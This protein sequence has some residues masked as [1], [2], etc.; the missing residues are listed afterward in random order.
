MSNKIYKKESAKSFLPPAVAGAMKRAPAAGREVRN[1]AGLVYIVGQQLGKGNFGSVSLC[2]DQFGQ[3]FVIKTLLSD[4]PKEEVF[5]EWKKEKD[6]LTSL[7]HPNIVHAYDGFAY[8]KGFYI[9][10]ERCSG[11]LRDLMK[12]EK[13]FAAAKVVELAGQMLSGLDHIHSHGIIHR[14]LHIDN[15]LYTTINNSLVLKIADFGISKVLSKEATKAMTFIGREFDYAPELVNHG[16]TSRQSDIYQMGLLL[17]FLYRGESAVSKTD[18]SPV[19]AVRGGMARKRA[20]GLGTPLG[21]NLT[22]LS[23]L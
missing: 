18:G 19:D 23:L 6:L 17:F 15:V 13:P 7:S 2:Q 22:A 10:L 12:K 20:E 4:R 16:Y 9:V 5:A 3:T 11:S 8:Q 1:D 21:G 14:D